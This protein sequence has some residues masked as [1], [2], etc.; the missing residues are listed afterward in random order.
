MW[1]VGGAYSASYGHD[2]S[3]YRVG[4]SGVS[5]VLIGLRH[6]LFEDPPIAADIG[7][8]AVD[9]DVVAGDVARIIANEKQ[10]HLGDFL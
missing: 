3:S 1:R 10:H 5:D 9:G 8:A 6:D 7:E 4:Y 2:N